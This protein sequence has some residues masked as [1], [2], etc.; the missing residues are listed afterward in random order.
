M[1]ADAESRL[2]LEAAEQLFMEDL[3]TLDDRL[4][5]HEYLLSHIECLDALPP[6]LCTPERK[7]EGCA[8]NAW[9]ELAVE[10]GLLHV[11]MNS[12]S[13]IIKGLLGVLSLLVQDRPCS[14][15]A[16]WEPCFL[17]HPQLKPQ[18]NV[19]RRKGMRTIVSA[20]RA[21]GSQQLT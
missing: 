13:L 20:I 21:F 2:T 18:L 15:V 19:D 16:A 10:E 6:E 12:D 7:V 3:E 8:S 9:M 5:Q 11:R 4:L 14:E 1:G 17:E